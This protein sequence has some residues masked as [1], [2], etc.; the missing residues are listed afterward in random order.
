MRQLSNAISTVFASN[1]QAVLAA[2]SDFLQL[3]V[4]WAFLCFPL[5]QVADAIWLCRG[6]GGRRGRGFNGGSGCNAVTVSRSVCL[7]H[8]HLSLALSLFLPLSFF[9]F[10]CCSLP[11]RVSPYHMHLPHRAEAML[12]LLLLLP[13]LLLLDYALSLSHIS[14]CGWQTGGGQCQLR[15]NQ[16]DN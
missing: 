6:R 4:L 12:H 11:Q 8:S 16:T 9:L 7:P 3:N 14:A 13:L 1:S 15:K 2:L 5:E 10:L